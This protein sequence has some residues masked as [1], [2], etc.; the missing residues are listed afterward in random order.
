MNALVR[1]R[2]NAYSAV[3]SFRD[4]AAAVNSFMNNSSNKDL[5]DNVSFQ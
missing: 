3:Q 4:S 1:L 2:E 5:Q